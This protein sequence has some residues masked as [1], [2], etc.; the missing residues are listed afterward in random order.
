MSRQGG[1]GRRIAPWALDLTAQHRELMAQ[2]DQL[3]VLD[4]RGPAT[5]NQQLQQRDEG[6][7][8]E[9]EEHLALLPE[10]TPGQRSGQI[11]VLAPFTGGRNAAFAGSFALE[12]AEKV[13]GQGST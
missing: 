9:G 4:L 2:H 11:R 5:A 8:D 6:E 12:V 13:C 7:V 3:E 1:H 10:A